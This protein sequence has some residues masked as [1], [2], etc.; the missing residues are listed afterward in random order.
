MSGFRETYRTEQPMR[1]I[2][3]EELFRD[4]PLEYVNDERLFHANS[5]CSISTD[6][7]SLKENDLFFAIS[8]ER[9]DGHSFI[10]K[11]LQ[12]G[13]WCIV[14]NSGRMDF[15][16]E[17]IRSDSGNL[18]IGV[19]DTRKTLGKIAENYLGLF[20]VKK[21]VVTGSAGKTTTKTLIHAVLSQRYKVVS[22]VQSY[23]NDIGVPKTIFAIDETTQ[24]LVQELGTNRPG[25][26]GYLSDIVHPG[27]ALITNIGPA[28]IGY[29]GSEKRIAREKKEALYALPGSGIAFLNA[30][31]KYFR[32]LRRGIEAR[33]KSFGMKRGDLCPEAVLYKDVKRTDFVLAGEVISIRASGM[34]T[35]LDATAAALV[36]MHLGLSP[37]EI[38]EGLETYQGETGRGSIFKEAGI[39]VIDESYNANPLSVLAA[40]NQIGEMSGF[41]KKIFVFGD[42]LELGERA[43]SYHR[44]IAP[45]IVKA[46]IHSIFCYGKMA[47]ITADACKA[48]GCREVFRF[49][50]IEELIH[51]LHEYAETKDL[52]LIKGSRA[53]RLER[54]VKSFRESENR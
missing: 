10:S 7:R 28:H 53:M 37:K 46:G 11:A 3:P 6:T 20:D 12:K 4:V 34:H 1:C 45:A 27:Y 40:V 52:I 19:A 49:S 13:A 54:V 15:V 18:F 5:V 47:A 33:V 22:S 41:K 32:F 38:K 42:M 29:F 14:F 39:T 2:R 43:A 23:N 17:H 8:G 48:L 24:I 9:F 51:H 35:V 30:D 25:E 36:G 21:I 16:R 50:E 31:D 44:S 26:I